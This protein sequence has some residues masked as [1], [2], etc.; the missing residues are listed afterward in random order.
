MRAIG[1]RPLVTRLKT[2]TESRLAHDP[3][4]R[5]DRSNKYR[6]SR[7][8]YVISTSFDIGIDIGKKTRRG[9]GKKKNADGIKSFLRFFFP[10]PVENSLRRRR[11]YEMKISRDRGGSR[12]LK[13]LGWRRNSGKGGER[14]R[15]RI[16]PPPPPVLATIQRGEEVDGSAENQ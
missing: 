12:Y 1:N 8:Y 10:I 7:P 11:K 13:I 3:E 15:E 4:K 14:K 6:L 9:R 5:A 2:G 16:L